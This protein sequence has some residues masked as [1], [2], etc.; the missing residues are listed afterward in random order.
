M[1]LRWW[2]YPLFAFL[3]LGAL[4]GFFV[5]F[6][7]AVVY[8]ELPSLKVLTDYRPKIPLR[9]YT[10]DGALI[11]EFGAERRSLVKIGAVPAVL[12]EAILAAEDE[13][14]YQHG[15]I[16]VRGV[17]RAALANLTAGG[18]KEGASTITMQVARNFFLT[19]KKTFSRK[20]SEALLSLKI[21]HYLTK[22]QIL[23]L[24]INQIYLG[25]RAYGF[26]MAAQT[27]FDK[28]LDQLTL[29][30]AAVLAGLPKAPSRYN[31]VA[32]ITLAKKRQAYVLGRMLADHNITSTQYLAAMKQP[33]HVH[34]DTRFSSVNAA[35]VAEMVRQMLY[36]QYGNAIYSRGFSVYTT[37][38]EADQKAAN[39]ALIH[40]VMAYDQRHGYRG[41][42]GFIDLSGINGNLADGIDK[43]LQGVHP[44]NGLIPAV[45]L[46]MNRRRVRAYLKDGRTIIIRGA[47]LHFVRKYLT[48]A[49]PWRLRLRR[50]ALIRVEKSKNN[51]RIVQLPRV[52][53]ALVSMDP[54][55]GAIRALVGGFDFGRSKFNH[56]TQAWRQA[57]SSFKPF[58]YSAALEK[59]FTPAT[60]INDAP[61][62]VNPAQ[63]GGQPWDPHNFEGGYSG[64]MRMREALAQ[65]KNLVSIR[66]L[67]AIG[68][69]YA[70]D[71]ITRFGFS[72]EQ[73]PP[74]L[75]MALGAGS[76]TPLQM[77][78]AYSVFANGG[79]YVRPYLI[80]RIL[81][82]RG[83]VITQHQPVAAGRG[84]KR[85]I[86]GRNAFL[87]TS[88]MASVIRHGTGARAMRL[89][90]HDLA[91]KTGT[92]NNF[93][94]AW[95]CGFNPNLVAVAWVGF[96]KPRTLGRYET[97]A[98]A[99]LPIWMEYMRKALAGVPEAISPV[100]EGVVMKNINPQTGAL[101][102]GGKGGIPEYFYQ[103]NVP[104]A[105]VPVLGGS[106]TAGG[107]TASEE[108][109]SQLF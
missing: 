97:G 1:A 42:E 108:V 57:G 9:V 40:G 82:A 38:R 30:E 75:T 46:S 73:H 77:V 10:A 14:F 28:P 33:L 100:P 81:D 98:R 102:P 25:Q 64:P 95:F 17:V 104:S 109:K 55:T 94:D 11:E 71:Y 43:A 37:I 22:D 41:P 12:K 35:Y 32:S 90:R 49:V 13:R 47:G 21:E 5:L 103:E 4:T 36:K 58:I 62:V 27:Y 20:F 72:P 101:M 50:G 45:I 78:T 24:Y 105:V 91:G 74:Y 44:S 2:R 67:Q 84:A 48:R 34:H 19:R 69:Q 29:G 87:M 93:V 99:A 79:F 88:M 96:D 3:T 52:E 6:A 56:V 85:V 63:T 7:A 31:P 60:V 26:A 92:T 59:G 66:I 68:T 89:G 39:Q 8:P 16:S 80:G 76:V 61:L 15:G 18:A 70:Q 86:D 106:G 65:S 107:V 54:V 53:A 23:E 51:W 83:N